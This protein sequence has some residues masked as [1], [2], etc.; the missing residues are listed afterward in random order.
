MG[1]L[2]RHFVAVIDQWLCGLEL[3]H[4]MLFPGGVS[5]FGGSGKSWR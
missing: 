1:K 2:Q 3:L 4:Q 5:V